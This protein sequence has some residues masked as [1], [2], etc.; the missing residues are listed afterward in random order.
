[1]TI[2]ATVMYLL[3]ASVFYMWAYRWPLPEEYSKKRRIYGVII[4]LLFSDIPLFAIEIDILWKVNAESGIQVACFVFTC[5]SFGYSGL[6]AWTYVMESVIK[7]SKPR[8][9]LGGVPHTGMPLPQGYGGGVQ[10]TGYNPNAAHDGLTYRQGGGMDGGSPIP[11]ITSQAIGQ[12]GASMQPTF[13]G[14]AGSPIQY[15]LPG[16]DTPSRMAAGG[17]VPPV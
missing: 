13:H 14:A 2:I 4:N 17:I 12:R 10:A 7:A 11:G 16:A 5:I 8:V 3:V 9:A 6:R 15:S 1:M